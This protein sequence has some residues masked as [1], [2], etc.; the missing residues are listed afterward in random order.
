V[1]LQA[2]NCSHDEL[3][4]FAPMRVRVNCV[5]TAVVPKG[6]WMPLVPTAEQQ[7]VPVAAYLRI[8]GGDDD[9][10]CCCS[11]HSL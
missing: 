7:H 1:S 5:P 9:K 10:C 6:E 4:M 3:S 2:L 8:A 11:P